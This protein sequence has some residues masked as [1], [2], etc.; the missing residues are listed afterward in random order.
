VGTIYWLV[1]GVNQ[2]GV[3]D[4]DSTRFRRH[5]TT[6]PRNSGALVAVACR[7]INMRIPELSLKQGSDL[8]WENGNGHTPLM[9]V[10]IQNFPDIAKALVDAGAYLYQPIACGNAVLER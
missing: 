4:M 10:I 2:P 8:E 5:P 6:M 3:F 7:D 1:F 9:M